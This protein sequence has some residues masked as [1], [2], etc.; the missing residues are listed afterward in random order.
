MYRESPISGKGSSAD[1]YCEKSSLFEI[2]PEIS[3]GI[4]RQWR[5]TPR[6]SGALPLHILGVIPDDEADATGK[7]ADGPDCADMRRVGFLTSRE[8]RLRLGQ[9]VPDGV[10]MASAWRA[11]NFLPSSDAP[12]LEN[13]PVD[14]ADVRAILLARQLYKKSPWWSSV[15]S[16]FYQRT[17]QS[18]Y[19]AQRRLLLPMNP[20]SLSPPADIHR[21][22]DSAAHDHPDVG[23]GRG[24]LRRDPPAGK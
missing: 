14:P 2:A 19:C 7:Y 6:W 12:A 13:N 23:P 11:A 10:K 9:R 18:P 24:F 17:G 20:I 21:Q 3:Q 16:L 15:C 4:P 5:P 8:N 22:C 1:G